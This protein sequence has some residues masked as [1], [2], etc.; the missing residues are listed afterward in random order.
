[1]GIRRSKSILGKIRFAD[2]LV[3]G[4]LNMHSIHINFSLLHKLPLEEEAIDSLVGGCL[5][6]EIHRIT[7]PSEG[8]VMRK[9]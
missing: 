4:V 3:T 2:I 5:L 1:M 7:T 9:F 6:L 8:L